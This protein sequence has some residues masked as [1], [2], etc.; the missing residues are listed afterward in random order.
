MAAAVYTNIGFFIIN[1]APE[2]CLYIRVRP[3]ARSSSNIGR[4]EEMIKPNRINEGKPPLLDPAGLRHVREV[5]ASAMSLF[6]RQAGDLLVL[7]NVLAAHGRMS[8]TGARRI[9]LAMT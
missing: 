8:V 6:R 4:I 7:D 5:M 3:A 1:R 2:L 9:L